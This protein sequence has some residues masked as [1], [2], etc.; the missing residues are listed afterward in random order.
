LTLF[1]SSERSDTNNEILPGMSKITTNIDL[2]NC[3][4]RN[5]TG[6]DSDQY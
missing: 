1:T 4:T 6:I 5:G 3:P 2:E